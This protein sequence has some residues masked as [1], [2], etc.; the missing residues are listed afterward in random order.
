MEKKLVVGLCGP[1]FPQE[2]QV[3]FQLCS[4]GD[5]NRTKKNFRKSS[6]DIGFD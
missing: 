2:L 3:R 6:D 1:F 4:L 5:P